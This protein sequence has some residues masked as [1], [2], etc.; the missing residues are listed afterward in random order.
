ML[1]VYADTELWIIAARKG[2][3]PE[4]IR[5]FEP[6][7]TRP[8]MLHHRK[9]FLS[10][11]SQ[12]RFEPRRLGS[13]WCRPRSL[14]S[15]HDM[16]ITG[17]PRTDGT[18]SLHARHGRSSKRWHVPLVNLPRGA[19]PAAVRIGRRRPAARR[20]REQDKACGK[21]NDERTAHPELSIEVR[22]TRCAPGA[23]AAGRAQR[24][25]GSNIDVARVVVGL[26]C[27]ATIPL[28][29]CPHN[30]TNYNTW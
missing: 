10:I 8:A 15:C 16:A 9:R 1:L 22:R 26:G 25:H 7:N 14:F 12:P 19:H 17:Q 30:C 11:G 4:S 2:Y 29:H 21:S 20:P 18:C 23:Q 24:P 27:P 28:L 6:L 5:C 13:S 3:F